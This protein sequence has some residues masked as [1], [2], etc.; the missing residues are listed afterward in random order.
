MRETYIRRTYG[1]S[2]AELQSMLTAQGGKCA[3]CRRFW[4]DC[5]RVKGSYEEA[6]FLHYLCVDHHHRTGTVRGLLCNAC[7]TA[8]GML[9]EDEERFRAAAMYLRRGA[10]AGSA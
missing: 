8:I 1:L 2:V 7:N 3:I 6:D 4:K 9:E 5:G 10:P